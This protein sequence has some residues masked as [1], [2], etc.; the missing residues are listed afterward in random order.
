MKISDDFFDE[1]QNVFMSS[2]LGV[3][4][5]LFS[6][7]A[8][9][10][11]ADAVCIFLAILIGNLLVLKV[12]G[13]HHIITLLVFLLFILVAGIPEFSIVVLLICILSAMGDEVGHELIDK[14]TDNKYLNLFFEYRF[15]MKVV[16]LILVVCGVFNIWIFVCFMLFEIF[17]QI[18][19]LV[20]KSLN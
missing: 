4:C 20:F 10:S 18:G 17:Y 14:M 6:A 7:L 8:S 16:M 12:D 13:L 5:G 11:D 9:V 19:G 15:L 2:I 1:N 3:F